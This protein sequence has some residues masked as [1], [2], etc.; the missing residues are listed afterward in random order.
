MG[1]MANRFFYDQVFALMP[2]CRARDLFPPVPAALPAPQGEVNN[3]ALRAGALPGLAFSIPLRTL[4]FLS[5]RPDS[6]QLTFTAERRS[7]RHRTNPN[8]GIQRKDV[9]Y[10]QLAIFFHPVTEITTHAHPRVFQPMR[11]ALEQYCCQ[12]A[13]R[14]G[15]LLDLGN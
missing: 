10:P 4:E 2:P 15:I 1:A 5:E 9:P 14:P 12:N 8:F 7:E 11:L 3:P 13:V 6:R